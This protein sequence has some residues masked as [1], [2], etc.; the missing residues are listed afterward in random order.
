MDLVDPFP[1][2]QLGLLFLAVELPEDVLQV[3]A[4]SELYQTLSGSILHQTNRLPA[5]H[6]AHVY[7]QLEAAIGVEDLEVD[8]GDVGYAVRVGDHGIDPHLCLAALP[9]E[10]ASWVRDDLNPSLAR[11]HVR[12]FPLGLDERVVSGAGYL[13]ASLHRCCRAS[14]TGGH[15]QNS[16]QSQGNCKQNRK[17]ALHLI[18]SF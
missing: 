13:S 4:L 12:A 11:V 6:F 7:L 15:R 17:R 14:T 16:H 18:H 10:R 3:V 1:Y 2:P 9:G 5:G 8:V